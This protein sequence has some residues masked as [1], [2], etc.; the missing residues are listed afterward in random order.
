[1]YL[2]IFESNYNYLKVIIMVIITLHV[3][4]PTHDYNYL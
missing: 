1:M 4:E 2:K 3:F